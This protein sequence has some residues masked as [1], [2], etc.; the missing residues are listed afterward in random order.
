MPFR[1][2]HD[3]ELE[4]D[5]IRAAQQLI[6]PAFRNSPQ[7]VHEG[8][9]DL[10]GI[11]VVLKV[12]TVNPIRAFKGRGT[13][14]A[15]AGLAGEGTIGPGRAVVA[16]STG[17]FGQGVAFAGRAHGIPAVIFADEHANPTKLERMRRFGATV[18]QEGRDFDAAREASEAYAQTHGAFLLLDGADSRVAAGAATLALEVTDG[19]AA[20][21]LP[22][23]RTAYVP[24]GN[25]A[26]ITGVGAWL[27]H[28]AP[29]CRIVGVAA[30]G[31]A[32]MVLSWEAGELVETPEAATYAEGI[33]CRV[34]IPEAL[35]MMVGRVDDL[36]LVSEDQ[37]RAAEAELRAAT[38]I[39]VEGAAAASWAGLLADDR[40]DGPGLVIL[41]GSNVSAAARS[42]REVARSGVSLGR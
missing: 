26:L 11:E 23:I 3:P 12:E 13:W 2:R 7:F 10:A 22:E 32:S 29:D 37:L 9:S 20:G 42:G 8:L 14:L 34:P 1:A 39:T 31:A 35:D 41:T 28:A 21:D 18:I 33:A 38:G 15:I 5:A 27:R 25:G 4:P 6:H 19:I 17:N 24:L 16:A 36:M 40:R 30:A